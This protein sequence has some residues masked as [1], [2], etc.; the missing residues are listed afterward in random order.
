V[1]EI[2]DS[3][4]LKRY[5]YPK[6]PHSGHNTV[7]EYSI[8]QSVEQCQHPAEGAHI[9]VVEQVRPQ[10]MEKQRAKQRNTSQQ[11][12]LQENFTQQYRAT[13]LRAIPVEKHNYPYQIGKIEVPHRQ[14]QYDNGTHS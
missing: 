11:Q 10:G 3:K 1:K 2:I 5:Y 7:D 8:E 12:K 4:V 13:I 14:P 6:S 9:H